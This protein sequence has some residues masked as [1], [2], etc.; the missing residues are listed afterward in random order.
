MLIPV[1]YSIS[2]IKNKKENL[3]GAVI[4]IT[5]ITE[6]KKQEMKLQQYASTDRLTGVLNRR[7]GLVFLKN[8]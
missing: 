5:D 3:I 7:T 2:P 1:E 4:V 6:R 8:I